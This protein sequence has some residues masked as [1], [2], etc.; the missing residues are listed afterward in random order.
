MPMKRF[1][2]ATLS[3]VRI[4]LRLCFHHPS[5][6]FSSLFFSLRV[7]SVAHPLRLL[8]G[9][10]PTSPHSGSSTS[11][12]SSPTLD[13]SSLHLQ[14]R[15]INV[16]NVEYYKKLCIILIWVII[17]RQLA[18]SICSKY[19]PCMLHVI[20]VCTTKTNFFNDSYI[21]LLMMVVSR[22]CRQYR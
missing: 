1:C 21:E 13:H 9:P 11:S 15:I 10:S 18:S 20:Y 19:D 5:S 7:S 12:L 14:R 6:L 4:G 3:F 22:R 16:L 2:S 17:I 8:V